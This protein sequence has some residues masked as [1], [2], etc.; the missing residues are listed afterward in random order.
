MAE[1]QQAGRQPYCQVL[2]FRAENPQ[3]SSAEMAARLTEQ[4]RPQRPFTATG[5][6]KV[7]ERAR[8][9]F[10]ELFIDDVAHSLGSPSAEQLEEEFVHL[11]LLP[12]CRSALARRLGQR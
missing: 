10:A 11:E 3:A 9:Q 6:R 2:K 4:L 12:Y 5:V 8:Q 1:H 7:L